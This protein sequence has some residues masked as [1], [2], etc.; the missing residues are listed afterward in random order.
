MSK[1]AVSTH[2]VKWP[3]RRRRPSDDKL[4]EVQRLVSL[5]R[6]ITA[7]IMG[8]PLPGRSALDQRN[9]SSGHVTADHLRLVK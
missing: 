6:T 1:N 3:G 5:P 8:D 9:H 7:E 4:A 2:G